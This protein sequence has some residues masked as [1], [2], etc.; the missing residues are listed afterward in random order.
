LFSTYSGLNAFQW[1]QFPII[2]NIITKFYSVTPEAVDWMSLIYMIIYIPFIFP[3]TWML[4][5]FGL[6][7]IAIIGSVLGAVGAVIK[8]ISCKQDLFYLA[9]I[10]QIVSALGN[11]FILGMP[12][13]IA[14]TWFGQTEVSTACS[15]GVFGNQIG[16]A[17]GFF[18]PPLLVPDSN[19]PKVVQTHL[20]LLFIITTVASTILFILVFLTFKKLPPTPPSRSQQA[21]LL[22]EHNNEPY[23]QSVKYLLTNLPSVLLILSY[24]INA[25]G[26]YAI[27]TLLNTEII[28]FFK[29][30]SVIAG[31]VGLIL[32]IAG[33]FG[34]II[35][36]LILDKTK[37]YKKTTV[38]IYLSSLT[39]MI[40]YTATLGIDNIYI[41]Y[42]SSVFLGFT[43]TAFLPVGFEFAAE[44]TY[45][46]SEGTSSGLLNASGQIFGIILTIGMREIASY[47]DILNAN[48][49]LCSALL[50]GTFLTV[51]VKETLRRSHANEDDAPTETRLLQHGL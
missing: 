18:V 41:L 16:I 39:A 11:V 17:L 21:Y 50:I 47:S 27:S 7:V 46:I 25:G 29:N 36:G 37:A 42:A 8:I 32:V 38:V 43:M 22:L 23:L 15:I 45:P 5:R 2:S 48:I 12:S 49:L 51:C 14:A 44:I 10:G 30:G 3:V 35:C 26:F 4:D 6:R 19:D 20:R 40:I 13:K 24:G 34:S 33:V 28:S 31:R 1:I 9:V